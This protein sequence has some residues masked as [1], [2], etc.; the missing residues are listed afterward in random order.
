MWDCFVRLQVQ[1][2]INGWLDK[3]KD[4]IQ[5]CVV[6]LMQE[7]KEPLVAVLFKE[8]E[9]G[10]HPVSL[11]QTVDI[12]TWSPLGVRSIAMSVSVCRSVCLSACIAQ[13][14]TSP[15]FTKFS[16]PVSCVSCGRGSVL[17]RRQCTTLC[18]SGFV[19]DVMF[20]PT[21]QIQIQAWSLRRC[22]LLTVTRQ[23][24]QINCTPRDEVCCRRLH[25]F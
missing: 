4:P 18:T 25:R 11:C 6:Q 23:V 14:T 9:E 24:V 2:N 19:D 21:G 3:N 7:S 1:Y 12:M 20:S 15:N 17:L 5:E 10:M 22:K 16:A 13:K 8:P